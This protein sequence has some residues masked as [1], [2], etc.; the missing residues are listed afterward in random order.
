MA[1]DKTDLKKTLDSYR[2]DR[3]GFRILDVP[4]KSYLMI[5]GS[6][7]PTSPAFGEAIGTLMPVAYTI[8]FAS[9]RDLDRDFVV[10]PIEGL[11]WADDMESFTASRD[12][13]L[14]RWTLMTLVPDWID[15]DT[16]DRAVVHVAEKK[17]LD[18]LGDVR[19]ERLSEGRSV[20]T[21]HVGSFDAEGPVLESMHHDFI[22][23]H[24]LTMT[25]RHHEIYLSDFRK[26]APEKLRT[27]LRQPVV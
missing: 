16:Y 13:N 4:D 21:L 7:A 14:W 10:P 9:K 23:S 20:Q 25:G 11:W 26:V 22:P 8:K 24:G 3:G 17:A 5:D 1:M 18:R 19:F 15:Q 6:G 2:C 12:K 27:I